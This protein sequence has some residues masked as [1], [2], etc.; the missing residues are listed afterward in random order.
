[1]TGQKFSRNYNGLKIKISG[2]KEYEQFRNQANRI[3]TKEQV[4][5]L[6]VRQG[7]ESSI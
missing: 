5:D 3:I 4:Y 6:F 7:V 1:M 2:L